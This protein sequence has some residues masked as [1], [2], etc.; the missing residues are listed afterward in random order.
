MK[1]L[2]V[3]ITGGSNGIGREIALEFAK[4]GSLV[5]IT[6]RREDKL[7]EV[8]D[9]HANIDYLQADSA[10]PDAAAKITDRAISLWGRIDVLINN[11][12]AGL[13]STIDN[14]TAKQVSD[15]FAVNIVGTSIL[16]KQCIPYLRERKG[17]IINI[18]SAVADMIMP[19]IS[20]YGASKAA[21]NYLTKAWAMELAP[22]IRVNAIAPG[23]TESGALTGMMGLTDEEARIAVEKETEMTPLKRR[24][25]PSDISSW[26]VWLTNPATAWTTGQIINVDGG[27]SL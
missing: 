18:S 19:G 6:G 24:G 4:S 26:V 12:G 14:I 22:D 27:F 5:L 21:I 16:T 13:T 9:M 1:E 20:H 15:L 11:V 2:V 17:T 10:N 3:I 7:K 23:S 8:A 25:V